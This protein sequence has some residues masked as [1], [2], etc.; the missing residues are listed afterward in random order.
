LQVIYEGPDWPQGDRF[1]NPPGRHIAKCY[2]VLSLAATGD[3]TAFGVL[4]DLLQSNPDSI[5]ADAT[6]DLIRRHDIRMYA[7]VGLGML[8]DPN[9]TDVLL[10][11]L[12]D[13][14]PYVRRQC[15][16]SLAKIGELRAIEPMLEA[17]VA[18]EA[19]DGLTLHTCMEKMTKVKLH[20]E[21]VKPPRNRVTEFPELGTAK[22]GTDFYIKVWQHWFDVRRSWTE[23]EFKD[24][25]HTLSES[26]RK[27]NYQA[28]ARLGIPALPLLIEKIEQ[29]ETDLIPLVSQLVDKELPE[30]ATQQQ[31]LEWWDNNKDK[32]TIA[33]APQS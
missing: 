10:R 16:W 4:T 8:A 29:G 30:D 22:L 3:P 18:D 20:I 1:S 13:T 21:T 6:E 7:A 24:K 11:K 33:F 17:A 12:H 26:K 15:F 25:Y 2:A 5:N 32:W 23:G 31:C 27:Y 28:I 19:I 9:A 14:N